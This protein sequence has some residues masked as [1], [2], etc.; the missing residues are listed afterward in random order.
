MPSLSSLRSRVAALPGTARLAEAL[1]V[2]SAE[3]TAA[4]PP[5]ARHLVVSALAP[6]RTGAPVL[7]VTATGREAED[8]H[9]ALEASL[10]AGAVG[11]FPSWETLPH[12]R[13]S[14]RSDT[15]GQRLS[16]LRRL[17]HPEAGDDTHGPL[18]VVVAPVR[19]VLQPIAKGLGDLRARRAAGR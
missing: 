9:S 12:E 4:A 7:A 16:V 2:P 11:L 3:V 17:A 6:T 18:S 10:G 19:A 14:P 8:L 5:G 1:A 13:L 15:V